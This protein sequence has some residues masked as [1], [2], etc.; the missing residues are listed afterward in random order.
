MRQFGQIKPNIFYRHRPGVYG[1]FF[2]KQKILLTRQTY[3]SGRVEWQI[4]GGGIDPGEQVLQA[5][6]RE[7][8]EETG[9]QVHIS[10]LLARYKR[11]VYMDDY[12]QYAQKICSIYYG[13]AIARQSQ[14]SEAGHEA[15]LIPISQALTLMDH[16]I[17]RAIL[18]NWLRQ[19]SVDNASKR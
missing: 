2:Q 11:A 15:D 6:Y 13:K 10:T 14:P 5:L 16:K 8:K 12:E 3:R 4:P 18:Q 17:D 1:L 9:W 19:Y 7:V